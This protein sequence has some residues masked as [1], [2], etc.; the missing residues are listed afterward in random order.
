[1]AKMVNSSA[2]SEPIQFKYYRLLLVGL[3]LLVISGALSIAF[4]YESQTLWYK[5]GRDK[6]I[7]RAGQMAGLLT[8]VL[9]FMQI[10][11]AARGKLLQRLFGIAALMRWHRGNGIGIFLLATCHVLLVLIPEGLTNLPI[12]LKY[13][14]E[15]VGMLLFCMIVAM[16]ISALWRKQLRLNYQRWLIVHK[17]SGY[18]VVAFVALHVLF[19]SDSF[20]H[21]VP[22][23]ALFASLVGVVLAVI[24]SK[25]PAKL[26]KV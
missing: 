4:V 6:I 13:W 21:T 16:V 10:L 11:L 7:L 25:I 22:R 1:M 20:E 9:L 24:V 19:V 12:G 23:T 26:P 15:M 17:L 18:L 3:V 14:P 5:I 8:A 2:K